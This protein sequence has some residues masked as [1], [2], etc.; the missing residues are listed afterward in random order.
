M[1]DAGIIAPDRRFRD[2]QRA[3]RALR[4]EALPAVAA[5][6]CVERRMD[7]SGRRVSE[8]RHAEV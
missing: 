1:I 7:A 4:A 8:A 5:C 3:V 6:R 2:L